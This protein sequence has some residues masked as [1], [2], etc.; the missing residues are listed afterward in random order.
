[1]KKKMTRGAAM[2][3]AALE[4]EGVELVFGFPG[5]AVLPLY[6]TLYDAPLKHLLVRH[7][8]AAVHAA[9]GYARVTGKPGVVFATSGPGATNLVTGIAN[10]YMDSVPLVLIT[11]QV[12]S[13]FIGTDAF[14]EADITGITLPITKHNYLVKSAEELPGILSE[15]F[16]IASSGRRGPVLI[17]IPKDVFDQEAYFDYN[18]ECHIPGYNPTYTGHA[19]QISRAVKAIR[20]A[21]RPVIFGGGGLIRSGASS[22]L[23]QLAEKARIPVILSLMGLGAYPGD[24]ELFLGMP[25]M[26]GSVTANYALTEADLIVATGVRFDDRVTGKLETFAQNAKIIHIDIDPAE[27]GKNVVIDIPIV[28]DVRQVLEELLR[29][30]KPGHTA[31]WLKQI[32]T[33]QNKYPIPIGSS[34]PGGA[35]K[36]QFVIRELSR[37]SDED[38]IVATDVGQHQMWS[39][40]HFAVRKPNAFLTSG[41]LGTMGYGF[42]AA[43]GARLAAP[44][45]RVICITGDGSFQMNIQELAT[46]VNNK[47]DMTIALINNGSL[48]MVRQWQDIFFD[49]RYSHTTLKGSPDFVKVAE[50][51]GARALRATTNEEATAAIEEAFATKGPVLIDFVVD[52]E[53]NVYPMVAP[54]RPI[55]EII[56]GGD[57]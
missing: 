50:A 49:K 38:T 10:A 44:E 52:P 56:T 35:L 11:G 20:D 27:I 53:E 6:D 28:G 2:I 19:G 51:Y 42:P 3:L 15:A 17:D 33:W 30:L 24:G 21:R 41:G 1:M 40:Q 8:Q 39:A 36:P 57:Y 47:L 5:G 34:N 46:V 14:Q 4:K 7:E 43:I 16:Y 9:D 26:H 22:V 29:K 54:N 18:T 31:K 32:E 48:G 37:L 13:Q 55:N 12:A 45:N 25:G 23:R